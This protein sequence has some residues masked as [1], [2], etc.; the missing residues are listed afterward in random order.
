MALAATAV[1]VLG[2][3]VAVFQQRAARA[4]ED[5]RRA[6]ATAARLA[7]EAATV[8][9]Q[10]DLAVSI[11]TAPDMRRIDLAGFDTSRNATARAYWSAA[12]GLLIVADRLPVP[13]PGRIYQV[14]LIDGGSTGPVSAGLIPGGGGRG[15]LIA[16]PPGRV[17]GGTITI[18]VTDE[19]A[20]GVPAPTGSKHLV[21]SL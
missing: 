10:A 4:A 15:M 20:G 2:G 21:G 18:A 7:A 11:L 3:L 6:D 1:L 13:A 16:P 8:A 14:W 5:L 17:T 9:A 12:S 19:P